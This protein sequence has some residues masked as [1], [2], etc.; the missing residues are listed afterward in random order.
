M[1]VTIGYLNIEGLRMDKHQACCSLIDAGLFDILFLSETWF[2][3]GF[4]YMSHPYS[5]IHTPYV[6]FN[7]K[8]RQSGG[9]LVLVSL[10]IRPLIRFHQVTSHGILLDVDGTKLLA[11]YLPP[12]LSQD[13]IIRA[14]DPFKNYSLLFGDINVR[15]KGVSHNKSVSVQ[16][17]QDF[18]HHWLTQNAFS[19]STPDTSPL[20]ITQ[21]HRDVFN[22]SHS[23]LLSSRFLP[24]VGDSYCLFPN[25][26]LD[27]FFHSNTIQPEVQ[28]L[29]ST[30]FNL[31]TV[32]Q[33]FVRSTIP[34][35]NSL[36]TELREGLGRFHLEKLE[37]PGISELLAD[38]WSKL[39]AQIDW[40]IKDVD[41]YDSVLL[42][43]LQAVAEEI[44][45]TYDI[46]NRRKAPDKFQPFLNSQLSATAAVRLFKRKQRNSNP[47]LI[48]QPEQ[49]NHTVLDEC[50]TKFESLFLTDTPTIQLPPLSIKDK[51]FQSELKSLVTPNKVS[52]FIKH[53]PKDKACGVDSIHTIL[54]N[55]LRTT[56]FSSR[57]S[58]IY[59]LCIQQGQT[60]RRWNQSVMYL[61][62]K[63]SEPP[64]TCNSVRPLS[65]LPMFRRIFEGLILP[66]F[67]DSTK[68]FTHL[69]P[70]QAGFRKGYST[71]SQAAICH[72]ALSTKSIQYAIFLDFQAAYDV[73]S[74]NHIM[75]S[76]QNRNMP[77]PLQHLIHSLMFQDASFQLIVNSKLSSSIQRN[78]GLPQGSP[79]SPVIFDMFIDSLIHELNYDHND[80][81]PQCLFFADDG[82][83]LCKTLSIAKKQLVVAERWAKENGMT[84]N[85][86]KCGVICIDSPP[87]VGENLLYLSGKELC[88]VQSYKY[89]GFHVTAEGIDFVNHI[90]LQTE[91]ATSFLK[92]VYVQCS[93][94]SPYTR[95]VIYNTFLR[96]KL[97]Y[98]APL[99]YAFKQYS[100]SKELLDP[101][102]KLQNEAIAWVFNSNVNKMKVLEGILG[103]LTVE[104]RFYH[105]R[106]SFQLHLNQ[107]ARSNP[108]RLLI[109]M[110]YRSQYLFTL[111]NDELYDQFSNTPDLPTAHQQLKIRMSEFLLSRRS[112][113]ISKSKSVLVNY[114]PITSRMAGLVD[115]VLIAPIQFQRLF[116]SWRRGA[117][118][119]NRVCICG[120]RW[121]RRHISCLPKAQLTFKHH[122]E[123][124]KCQAEQSKN[125]CELDYLLNVEEWKVAFEL[126]TLWRSV[127]DSVKMADD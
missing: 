30:Q 50:I 41:V 64:I 125:F 80:I 34:L 65:I 79:L 2:P 16:T 38:A 62:P 120:E 107:S 40:N 13:G 94:W 124:L 99:S 4:N 24:M 104:Q 46:L 22:N 52:K 54:L 119:L 74:A 8:S 17:L 29:G 69:H 58:G 9:I 14:L 53:Y 32:H 91:S 86:P 111:R 1:N 48:I 96:P 56:Q 44:L 102:Q 83:L 90:R 45:G 25:C 76:L 73:T 66:I 92:Y 89:L 78:R 77:A 51:S 19:M 35:V 108:I 63:K 98:G 12:S 28:L 60:P 5:F 123:Y 87:M 43:S 114:I 57:L 97:E 71:L 11:V 27:H 117:L 109:Q 116:L 10:R 106:C 72:H 47:S 113:I 82:L 88:I 105:L 118:F 49:D 67:I 36:E 7:E 93:E 61:L 3:K 33:Y 103:T 55:S 20:S 42:N 112:G 100:T 115:K 68:P 84:Y 23:Q 37:K 31:K 75:S 70:A 15:F 121:H 18:W 122:I 26:E 101:I 21:R 95:Y 39:D 81:L 6:K 110:S 59:S 127:L 85:V 126:I